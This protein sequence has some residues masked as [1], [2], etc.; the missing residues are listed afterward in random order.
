MEPK[1]EVSALPVDLTRT[2]A[3][4]FVILL[5]ASIEPN[6][7]VDFMS[8]QGVE[9]WWTADVYGSIARTA[10]PLFIMLTGALLLQPE[11]TDEPLRFFFKKRWNRIG[12]PVIFWAIVFLAWAFFVRRQTF[13]PSTILQDALAGPYVHFWYVYLLVGL[14]LI[15]P[16]FRVFV[17]HADWKLVKYFLWVWFVG[18][19]IVS[20]LMLS[21]DISPQAVWFKGNVFILTGA[22]GYFVL[23]AFWV[24]LKFRS[25]LLY[26]ALALSVLWTI[27]G[28]F[29]LTSTLGER[30]SAFFL[31]ASS[32]STIIASVALFLI[33]TSIPT[34]KI[35]TKLPRFSQALRIISLN[36]L[37]IYLFHVIIL[38]TLQQGYLGFQISVTTLN[39]ILS[40]PLLTGV[41]LLLS[42]AI[43]V[44]LKKIPYVA[45]II[46]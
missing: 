38:E 6:L 17:A 33:L 11:K 5:H 4:L 2:I 26:V 24:R 10:V 7:N 16:V 37:P 9:L 8:P 19:G 29:L 14:Y 12:V 15:T 31:D 41:T 39:P 35:E 36:T 25:W 42:L 34:Q 23:G 20:L 27:F 28:T 22:I 13:T 1:N 30:Y 46:G 32:F 44:P 18:T 3:I 40:I 21:P 43:I 45:K